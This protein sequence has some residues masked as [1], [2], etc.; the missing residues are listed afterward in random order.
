M[1]ET[2][3]PFTLAQTQEHVVAVLSA[4]WN[5]GQVGLSRVV[6]LSIPLVFL[7]SPDPSFSLPPLLPSSV[8]SH[9]PYL[10]HGVSSLNM[11]STSVAPLTS[12][13]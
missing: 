4:H 1:A 2:P 3:E 10:S 13:R 6:L 5:R 12:Q 9:L 11:E 7:V 8:S